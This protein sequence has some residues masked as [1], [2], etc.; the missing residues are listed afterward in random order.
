MDSR[1]APQ[2]NPQHQSII[3]LIGCSG[4]YRGKGGGTPIG[5]SESHG[6]VPYCGL[7]VSCISIDRNSPS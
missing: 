5:L 2:Q 1:H 3:R 7:L 6:S 4:P